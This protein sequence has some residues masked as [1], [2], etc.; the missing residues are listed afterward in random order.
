MSSSNKPELEPL[1]L[2]LLDR[3]E[4][5]EYELLTWGF[6]EGGFSREQIE[7][8]AQSLIDEYNSDFSRDQLVEFLGDRRLLFELPTREGDLRLHR[9]RFAESLRLMANLRQIFSPREWATGP[10]LVADYRL[11][12]RPRKYPP[13]NKK[14]TEFIDA[15][16]AQCELNDTEAAALDGLLSHPDF[17][18]FQLRATIHLLRKFR[19]PV[20]GGTMICAGTA[21]GKTLAFYLPCL[22]KVAGLLRK[23]SHWT[24]VIAVYPRKE[25]LKDQFT[26]VYSQARLLDGVTLATSHRKLVMGAFFGPTP[27]RAEISDLIDKWQDTSIGFICPY[28]RCPVCQGDLV[29]ARHDIE[30]R[31]EKLVCVSRKCSGQVLEDEI[32]LTRARMQDTPPD[33]LFT[34]TEMLNRESSSTWSRHVFG[35]GLSTQ[36]SPYAMLLDETHTYQGT[37]GAQVAL[38]VRRWRNMIASPIQFVGLSATLTD[39]QG[40]FADLVNLPPGVVTVIDASPESVSIGKEYHVIL[41]GDPVSGTSLLST[42]IQTAMLISR[43][44]DPF[45]NPPSGDVFGRKLFVFTDDLDVTNRLFHNLRDAEGLYTDSGKPKPDKDSLASYR[46]RKYGRLLERFTEGQ[47]WHLCEEIGHNLDNKLKIGRTSSQDPGVESDCQVVV[48]TSSLEVGYD[49]ANVGAVL[50]HKAPIGAASL[51]QRRGRAGRK[52]ITRPLTVMVLSDYGR[53]RLAYQAYEQLFDPVLERQSLPVHNRYVLRMQMVFSFMDWM[54]TQIPAEWRGSVWRD[55][56]GPGRDDWGKR[57]QEHEIRVIKDLLTNQQRRSALAEYLRRSLGIPDDEV[58]VLFW[59]PPRALMTSVLPTLLRRLSTGWQLADSS[60]ALQQDY[61]VGYAPLPDFVPENLFSD[62]SLPEVQVRTPQLGTNEFNIWSMPLMQAMKTIAPGNVTRRFGVSH[63]LDSHWVAPTDYTK[64]NQDVTVEQVCTTYEDVGNFRAVVTDRFGGQVVVDLRCLRPWA[65]TLSQIPSNV[66]NSSKAFLDW[67]SQLLNPCPG[68]AQNVPTAGFLTKLISSVTFYTHNMRCP[69]RVRR[70]ALGSKTSVLLKTGEEYTAHIRFVDGTSGN[71]AAIGFQHEVDG[72]R[73]GFTIP[74]DFITSV[75]RGEGFRACRV[76]YF[77]DSVVND[78]ELARHGNPF[79]LQWLAQVYLSLLLERAMS[80]RITVA[81]AAESMYSGVDTKDV[82]RVLDC[83]FRVVDVEGNEDEFRD[84]PNKRGRVH[85]AIRELFHMTE[86]VARLNNLASC[87]WQEVD[88]AFE[89][90]LAKRVKATVGSSM[91]QACYELSR[92]HRV[93]DLYLDIDGGPMD[94]V[95]EPV[96]NAKE[97]SIW[98]T[99]STIGGVGIIEEVWR[100]YCEDPKR[101]FLLAEAALESSEFELVDQEL[102]NIVE[103]T[104]SSPGLASAFSRVREAKTNED[105]EDVRR[106]LIRCLDALGVTVTRSVM[107]SLNARVLRPGSSPE[108]DGLIRDMVKRWYAEEE[109]LG[110]EIDSRVFAYLA[111]CDDNLTSRLSKSLASLGISNFTQSMA[112]CILYPL[113]W[114]RGSIVRQRAL[115]SYNPYCDLPHA[116]PKIIRDELERQTKVVT[117]ENSDW[118]TEVEKALAKEGIVKIFAPSK[119]RP[120]LWQAILKLLIEPVEVDFLHVY[121]YVVRIQR[122]SKGTVATL[123]LREIT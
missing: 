66:S 30:A 77:V 87:L 22:V 78:T 29:W 7:R 60:N 69:L 81:Q 27:Y 9:T 36:Q 98:I 114:P 91:L 32:I 101:F 110:V 95:I 10:R 54:A 15:V 68:M 42:S 90:W 61:L 76:D 86:V 51:L 105:L 13:R 71:Q 50:Q 4:D 45:E 16:H 72:I 88:G 24:Q 109:R 5:R 79:Q 57:R 106:S 119:M 111:S 117:L 1:A 75:T 96:E 93:G 121:P 28:L 84:E 100:R 92:R 14:R 83:V 40:F 6:L 2:S 46:H 118:R 23:N 122:S 48:A 52:L 49:D 55:L 20:T 64:A 35:I 94:P 65:V 38:L 108:T 59:E 89:K 31:R 120:L 73:F 19:G 41:R 97:D 67:Q 102:T 43:V 8:L 74:P 80:R 25:L 12:V 37:H 56:A 44:L 115:D 82:A 21:A 26:E 3:L 116:D 62:L 107:T 104:E 33:I 17:S 63:I 99:E 53:D 18:D 112:Y 113:L 47:W 70:F 85:D 58:Q 39:A 103:L 34:T 123:D 11:V